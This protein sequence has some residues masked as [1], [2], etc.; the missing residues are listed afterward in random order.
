MLLGY[1]WSEDHPQAQSPFFGQFFG[2]MNNPGY[3]AND[4]FFGGKHRTQEPLYS[5]QG[6]LSYT[7]SPGMWLGLDGTYY[8]GGRT[9]TDSVQDNNFQ[10]NTR[11]GVTFALPVNRHNSIKLYASTGVS[12]RTGSNFDTVGI[13]WQYRWGG[14]F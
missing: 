4:D 3:T 8:T 11:L 6:H 13:A 9:P 2:L 5:L 10:G 1:D 14:G 12:T 7:L